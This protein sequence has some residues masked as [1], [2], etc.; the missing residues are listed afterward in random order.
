MMKLYRQHVLKEKTVDL[1]Q[2]GSQPAAAPSGLV[3]IGKKAAEPEHDLVAG[4]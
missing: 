2:I 1:V 4:D 3:S